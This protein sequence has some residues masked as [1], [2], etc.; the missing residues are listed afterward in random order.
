MLG[1]TQM[2]MA[3]IL[4]IIRS[5]WSH[6]EAG[7]IILP[8]NSGIRLSEIILYMLSPE[9]KTLKA[10]S[11]PEYEDSKTKAIV[12][13]RLKDNEYWLIDMARKI[14]KEQG[15]LEKYSKAVN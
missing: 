12:K 15:K 13:K 14:A 8:E 1:L 7:T 2:E 3:M 11:K 5:Q 6:Y 10:L 9:A 4:R